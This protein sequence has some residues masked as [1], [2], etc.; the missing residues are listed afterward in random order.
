M[1]DNVVWIFPAGPRR[2]IPQH[3]DFDQTDPT[4][5][6]HAAVELVGRTATRRR[7]SS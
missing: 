3:T 1:T 4:R 2:T 7:I 5:C 6:D